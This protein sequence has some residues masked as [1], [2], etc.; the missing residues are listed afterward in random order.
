MSGEERLEIRAFELLPTVDHHDLGQTVIAT[1]AFT[2]NHHAG[3]VTRRIEREI[4]RQQPATVRVNQD[5]HPRPAQH[6]AC[7]R[8]NEFN[9][10]LCMVD[11]PNFKWSISM[12]GSLQL[13]L[14][15]ERLQCVSAAPTLPFQLLAIGVTLARGDCKAS[16]SSAPPLLFFRKKASV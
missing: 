7:A 3:A 4:D 14:E 15:I 9:V 12:P 1:D 5:R 10:Q 16:D 13:K 6:T 2:K 11:M 8:T